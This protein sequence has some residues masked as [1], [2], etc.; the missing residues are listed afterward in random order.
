MKSVFGLVAIWGIV[1]VAGAADVAFWMSRSGAYRIS[2]DSELDPLPINKIHRWVIHVETPAGE[3]VDDA[4]LSL[5]GGMPLHDHG[6]PTAPRMTAALGNGNYQ[7]E[8]LRFHMQGLWELTL[9]VDVDGK[10][11]SVAI[12]LIL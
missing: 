6:L 9:T 5:T 2:I 4:I 11:D 1:N 3:P 12:E 10:R 7:I 8:G